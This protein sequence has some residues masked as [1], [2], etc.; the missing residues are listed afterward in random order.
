MAPQLAWIG[1]GNM[2]RGMCKNLVEK[3]NLTEPLIIYNRTTKRAE[4]LA[5]K[6][7]HATVSTSLTDLASQ[8]DII[9]YCLGDDPAVLDAV[10][11]LLKVDVSGKV[12]VDCSTIHPDSTAKEAQK[13]HAKGAFFVACPVFGAPAMAD[14]GQLVCVLAG[15]A[16]AVDKVKPYCEGVMGRAVIDFSGKE[17]S[18]A[19]LLKVI[20]NTFIASMVDTLAEGHV[21]AEK[22]G[23]GTQELHSFIST[24]FPGPVSGQQRGTNV[25]LTVSS[26]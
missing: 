25:L 4:D 21:V 16:A 24:M 19:T 8:A 14:S 20:G 3:G 13:I 22:S 7:G 18:K 15:D 5:A 9:F 6:I 1:L 2:G 12:L 26:K 23:L 11:E 10:D 17:P